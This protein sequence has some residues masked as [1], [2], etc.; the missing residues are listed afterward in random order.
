MYD[1]TAIYRFVGRWVCIEP[2]Y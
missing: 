1:V 2:A